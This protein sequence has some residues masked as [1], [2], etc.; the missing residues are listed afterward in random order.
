MEIEKSPK[1]RVFQEPI[2]FLRNHINL[3][4]PNAKIPEN[5]RVEIAGDDLMFTWEE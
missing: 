2:T 4:Y 3:K 1:K 5:A